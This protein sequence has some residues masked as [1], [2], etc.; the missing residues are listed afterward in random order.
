MRSRFVKSILMALR[1][2]L[3]V[4]S[5]RRLRITAAVTIWTIVCVAVWGRILGHAFRETWT[6][7]AILRGGCVARGCSLIPDRRQLRMLGRLSRHTDCLSHLSID[8]WFTR[9]S[10][11]VLTLLH[12]GTVSFVVSLA[13]GFLLLLLCLPLFSNL[14][15]LCGGN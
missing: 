4:L 9:R 8:R 11:V 1:V 2:H 3:R 6:L 5:I 13:C 14:F 7:S 12:I 15:E 10:A